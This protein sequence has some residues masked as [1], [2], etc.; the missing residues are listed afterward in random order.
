V[1]SSTLFLKLQDLT[2]VKLRAVTLFVV[3]K[4]VT[5]KRQVWRRKRGFP[6]TESSSNYLSATAALNTA[7]QNE[8]APR[9]LNVIKSC[10]IGTFYKFVNCRLSHKS[11]IA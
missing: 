3:R 9:E 4:P 5:K 8:S 10:N 7:V 6:S 11:G 1:P 2:I